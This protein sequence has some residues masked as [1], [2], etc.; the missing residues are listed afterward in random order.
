MRAFSAEVLG[1]LVL[2]ADALKVL[3]LL[4]RESGEVMVRYGAA[5]ALTALGHH[6]VA[7]P[8]LEAVISDPGVGIVLRSRAVD[9][10]GQHDAVSSLRRVVGLASLDPTLLEI[11]AAHLAA[12]GYG[13]Q[14]AMTLAALVESEHVDTRVKERAI[15]DLRAVQRLH[16]EARD[17][18]QDE[19]VR[20]RAVHALSELGDG[21]ALLKLVASTGGLVR[22]AAISGVRGNDYREELMTTVTAMAADVTTPPEVRLE[23]GDVLQ[24]FGAT[25]EAAGLKH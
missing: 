17:P 12:H 20:L 2:D 7:L 19:R 6:E 10:L 22:L 1:E 14:A 21:D 23:A 9:A 5:T 8:V 24:K 15:L 16:A 4:S 13:A 18:S 11:A 3:I 25:A